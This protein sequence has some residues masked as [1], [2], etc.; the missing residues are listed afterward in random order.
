MSP[1]ISWASS[2]RQQRVLSMFVENVQ[3][4][5]RGEE[6]LGVVDLEIGY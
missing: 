4:A 2:R 6:L 3:R 1:H 5:R